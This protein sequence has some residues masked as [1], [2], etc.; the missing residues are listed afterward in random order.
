MQDMRRFRLM[1]PWPVAR[2]QAVGSAFCMHPA[3]TSRRLHGAQRE[4]PDAVPADRP[5]ADTRRRGRQAH[6]RRD[7]HGVDHR[8]RHARGSHRED[9][10]FDRARQGRPHG[11][12]GTGALVGGDPVSAAT[13]PRA[14]W[15][16]D[17]L[18]W[19]GTLFLDAA[20]RLEQRTAEPDP[21]DPWPELL[22]P[23]E[24]VFELRNRIHIGY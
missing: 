11:G 19:I 7:G 6:P 5:G 13:Y 20:T 9:G 21:T 8:G 15:Y 17:G 23:H 22:P 10:R 18:R 24:R 4:E 2:M 1:E 14:A 12:A 16:A 3:H